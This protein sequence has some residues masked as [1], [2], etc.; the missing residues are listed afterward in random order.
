[1]FDWEP[2]VALHAMQG[3]R[4]SSLP[5]GEVSWFF[6]SCGGKLGYILELRRGWPLKTRVFSGRLNRAFRDPLHLKQK[7]TGSLSHTYSCGKTPLELL[8]E[9]FLI[10]SVE[11]R[12][13][14]LISTGYGLH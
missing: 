14:A 5:E 4:A 6:S 11:D 9:S 2:R 7:N 13:S 10:S 1:M 12:E 8:V 3:Y